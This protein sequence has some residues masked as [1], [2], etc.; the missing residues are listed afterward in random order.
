MRRVHKETPWG[1]REPQGFP[2]KH[3]KTYRGLQLPCNVVGCTKTFSRADNL[4]KYRQD[5]HGL[6][7]PNFLLP[8]KKVSEEEFK[9]WTGSSERKDP[10]MLRPALHFSR[11]R[12]KSISYPNFVQ[13]LPSTASNP[14]NPAGNGFLT[15]LARTRTKYARNYSHIRRWV[16]NRLV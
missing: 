2:R 11:V 9:N 3:K 1:E 15:N 4:K 6:E 8:L 7:A 13:R 16:C 12:T 10:T 5:K 14:P